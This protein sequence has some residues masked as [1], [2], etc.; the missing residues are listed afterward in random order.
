MLTDNRETVNNL[1]LDN[2]ENSLGH[3][4]ELS[5]IILAQSA[6]DIIFRL[7]D[8]NSYVVIMDDKRVVRAWDVPNMNFGLKPGDL[9]PEGTLSQEAFSSGRR[10]A[11][12]ISRENSKF[13]FGYTGVSIPI[14]DNA[15]KIIGA[16]TITSPVKNQDRLEEIS[17]ELSYIAEQTAAATE[18]IANEAGNL[19]SAVETLNT[20][21]SEV[22]S[23]MYTITEVIQLINDIYS[24]C[25][26][27]RLRARFCCCSR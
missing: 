1:I 9:M 26:C 25:S 12:H 27:R 20:N 18:T 11:K 19:A 2:R 5:P 15:G 14:K 16:F 10:I 3:P 24:S 8:G 7:F 21:S 4:A 17:R 23:G 22:Q 6:G 13:G